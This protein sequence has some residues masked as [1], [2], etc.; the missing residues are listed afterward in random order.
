MQGSAA[1]HLEEARG[2][3]AVLP[4]PAHIAIIMDGN[5]RWAR[6]RC[7]P[8]FAGHHAGVE[9]VRRIVRAAAARNIAVLTLYSFSTENWSR[10]PEE[11]NE[12]M[13]LLRRFIRSDLATLHEQNV[14]IRVIGL[15]SGLARDILLLIEEAEAKTAQNTGITL[16]LAFNYGARQEIVAATQHLAREV[17]AGRLSADAIDAETF[18]TALQTSG[19]P[20]PDLVIRTSGEV[21]LSNF[22]LWQAAYSEFV[23]SPILWPDFD[24]AALDDAIAQFR[25]RDR[26]FGGV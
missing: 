15:R 3:A 6:A 26:R 11:V 18:D 25:G 4:P 16:V 19:L 5:G 14:R 7:L 17:A 22:L 2:Q 23:F 12:L 13:G 8:R 20:D 21:R 10:P 24:E 9:A 1:P